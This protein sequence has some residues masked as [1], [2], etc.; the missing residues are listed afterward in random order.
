MIGPNTVN[1][2]PPATLAAF[3]NHGTAALTLTTDLDDAQSAMDELA[4]LGISIDEVTSELEDQ[5]V[6][7]FS[8]AFSALLESVELRR[9]S[10]V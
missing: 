8:N 4:A 1:T 9:K 2:V 5:G 6:K 7:S 3:R 10:V